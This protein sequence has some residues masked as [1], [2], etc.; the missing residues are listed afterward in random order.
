LFEHTWAKGFR[1][2]VVASG[3][4]LLADIRV[5]GFVVEEV[6]EAIEEGEEGCHVEEDVRD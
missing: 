4:V 1:D 2:A 3:G 6:M 5:P